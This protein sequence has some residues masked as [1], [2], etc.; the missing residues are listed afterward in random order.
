MEEVG[1][2][3]SNYI[4][5]NDKSIIL[6]WS[7]VRVDRR[8]LIGGH[9]FLQTCTFVS[10]EILGFEPDEGLEK[11]ADAI[12][13]MDLYRK[14]FNEKKNGLARYFKDAP[15]V[16]WDFPPEFVFSRIDNVVSRLKMIKVSVY[17]RRTCV[18]S[19]VAIANTLDT[20]VCISNIELCV[21]HS[22]CYLTVLFLSS[23][24]YFW[25]VCVVMH[26]CVGVF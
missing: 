20:Y 16:E 8:W 25:S 23:L 24:T 18:A 14:T 4:C 17:F 13:I 10:E 2:S 12:K 15:V 6:H 1:F 7:T 11:I 5:S 19:Y 26:F 21:V 3:H 9:L 22:Y